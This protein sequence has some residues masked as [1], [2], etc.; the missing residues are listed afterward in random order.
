MLARTSLYTTQAVD[1][2][3]H[4][5]IPHDHPDLIQARI[6]YQTRGKRS[7]ILV[8]NQNQHKNPR[9]VRLVDTVR[10]DFAKSDDYEFITARLMSLEGR[11]LI[12]RELFYYALYHLYLRNEPALPKA[13]DNVRPGVFQTACM[14]LVFDFTPSDYCI[15]ATLN[16]TLVGY[17]NRHQ[18][19]YSKFATTTSGETE[20]DRV[21][22][23][24]S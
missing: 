5:G 9:V 12:D 7:L 8:I 13:V 10:K 23:R 20:L 15:A 19:R 1:V 6:D 18:I 14:Q 17:P 24:A 3:D 4:I 22:K 16:R 2:A 21:L 11:T